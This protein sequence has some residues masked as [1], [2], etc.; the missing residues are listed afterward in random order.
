MW[1]RWMIM[2]GVPEDRHLQGHS[3]RNTAVNKAVML[4]VSPEV[5]Q[6]MFNWKDPT[7]LNDYLRSIHKGKNGAP[8]QISNMSIEEREALIEHIF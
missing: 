7:M 4:D 5:I 1:K 6:K 3:L 8:R 2:M